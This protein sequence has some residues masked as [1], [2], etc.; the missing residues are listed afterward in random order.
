MSV[1]GNWQLGRSRTG[2]SLSSQRNN[3]GG[4]EGGGGRRNDL[5]LSLCLMVVYLSKSALPGN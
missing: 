4:G 1:L 3:M 5:H 2:L